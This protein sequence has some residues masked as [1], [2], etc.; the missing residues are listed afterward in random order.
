MADSTNAE[1]VFEVLVP[2]GTTE[3]ISQHWLRQAFTPDSLSYQGPPYAFIVEEV[4]LNREIIARGIPA[5]HLSKLVS[6]IRII[7]WATRLVLKVRT[8]GST[9]GRF[10][11]TLAGRYIE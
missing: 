7:E 5:E 4:M 11:V 9:A 1:M 8:L 6:H 10:R 3:K 2:A